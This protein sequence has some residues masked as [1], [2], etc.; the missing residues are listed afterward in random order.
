MDRDEEVRRAQWAE[1]LLKDTRWIEAWQVFRLKVFSEIENAR[2]DEATIRG[3]L[4]LGVANDVRAHFE[5]LI[6]KGK[7]A[8]HEIMLEKERKQM[9]PSEYPRPWA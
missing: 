4:M 8:A 7:V 9:A 2:S 6:T 1:Q 5:G 3:K